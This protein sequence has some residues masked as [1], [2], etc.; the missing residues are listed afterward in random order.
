[1]NKTGGFFAHSDNLSK[2]PKKSSKAFLTISEVS[3][4]LELSQHV[5]RFWETRFDAVKPMK[6]G[7]GRRYYRPKDIEVLKRIRNLLYKDGYTI[8]GVQKIFQNKAN[9]LEKKVCTE[10][11]KKYFEIKNNS[12][13][14]LNDLQ[15][16]LTNLKIIRTKLNNNENYKK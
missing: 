6:R 15:S 14:T 13:S 12:N 7:G 3:K 10:E 16:I 4:K 5:L 11:Q 8:K 1:M 2:F 9:I